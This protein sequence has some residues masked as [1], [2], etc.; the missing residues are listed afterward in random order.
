[1]SQ[2]VAP[3]ERWHAMP[4]END[5]RPARVCFPLEDDAVH[6]A[7]QRV[8]RPPPTGDQRDPTS[9][10]RTMTLTSSSSSNEQGHVGYIRLTAPRLERQRRNVTWN[11]SVHDNE[12]DGKKKSKVCCIFHGSSDA[13]NKD[14][15]CLEHSGLNDYEKPCCPPPPPQPPN[16]DNPTS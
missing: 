13:T 11:A 6:A 1:M 4:S 15:E 5:P 2:E 10:S 9:A 14:S 8:R 3:V 7:H 16:K 12:H